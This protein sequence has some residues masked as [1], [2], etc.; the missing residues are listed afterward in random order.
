M[1]VHSATQKTMNGFLN[2]LKPPGMSSAAAVGFVK[3]LTGEKAGHAGTLDPEA[4]GVL[5]VMIGK[6][7]RVLPYFQDKTKEYIA[8]ICFSCATDT[9]DAQGKMTAPGRGMPEE[10]ALRAAFQAFTG[11]IL[12]RPPAYSAVKRD[13]QPL[14]ALARKGQLVETEPRETEIRSIE[15]M[16]IR[17]L[18]TARIRIAC[19]SGTYIRTLCHDIGAYLGHPAH[20]RL[21]IRTRSGC[22]SLED[23]HT[24]EVIQ[25]AA[26]EGALPSLLCPMETPVSHLRAVEIRGKLLRQVL[27]GVRPDASRIP[28]DEGEQFRITGCGEWIALGERRGE[29][30]VLPLILTD[31]K[32][33]LSRHASI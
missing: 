4:C 25:T 13:G 24:P 22:F 27:N 17:Q 2:F 6:A 33:F 18:D 21:L 3:R 15:L 1:L 14:Y 8:E 28:A 23:S 29:T 5:P 9:Q 11:T 32:D 16:D 30:I 19:G 31:Q 10:S 7:T 26:Q 20:M 12:Q